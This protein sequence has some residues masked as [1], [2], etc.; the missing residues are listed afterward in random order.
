MRQSGFNEVSPL[1]EESVSLYPVEIDKAFQSLD[2]MVCTWVTHHDTPGNLLEMSC[3]PLVV[4]MEMAKDYPVNIL[5]LVPK[6]FQCCDYVVS[7][8]SC[9]NQSQNFVIYEQGIGFWKPGPVCASNQMD[10][11][12]N[13]HMHRIVS[14]LAI[15][16]LWG[17][18]LFLSSNYY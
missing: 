4:N 7:T 18:T 10:L 9:I 8:C 12:F 3:V 5:R 15:Y 13:L 6:I 1:V 14:H 17:I 11:V 16:N 2:S